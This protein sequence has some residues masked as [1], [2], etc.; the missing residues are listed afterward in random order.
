MSNP[1]FKTTKIKVFLYIT[2]FPL[3]SLSFEDIHIIL[4]M[5]DVVNPTKEDKFTSIVDESVPISGLF[6]DNIQSIVIFNP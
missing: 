3:L 4:L 1:I 2:D 6:R 5:S